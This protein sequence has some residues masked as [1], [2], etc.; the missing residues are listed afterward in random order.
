M[1]SFILT[2]TIQDQFLTLIHKIDK[3][4]HTPNTH[5]SE[6]S[7]IMNKATL[8]CLQSPSLMTWNRGPSYIFLHCHIG[9]FII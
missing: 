4:K 5:K 1:V 8:R 2:A 6:S 9:L 3:R 7:K